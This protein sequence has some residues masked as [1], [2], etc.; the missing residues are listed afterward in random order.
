MINEMGVVD[1]WEAVWCG[2][3]AVLCM[4]IVMNKIIFNV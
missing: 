4:N 1:V 3:C 2:V